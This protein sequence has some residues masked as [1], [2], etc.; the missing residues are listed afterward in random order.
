MDYVTEAEALS[1]IYENSYNDIEDLK[2]AIGNRNVKLRKAYDLAKSKK[3]GETFK[4]AY[5]GKEHIKKQYSQAFCSPVKKS[6]KK[7]SR[8]KDKYWNSIDERRWRRQLP[9]GDVYNIPPETF[10]FEDII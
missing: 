8:C 6:S 9:D 7:T 4:C 10:Y 2:D 5:C 3:V 1:D